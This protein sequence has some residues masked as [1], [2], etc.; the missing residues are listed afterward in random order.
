MFLCSFPVA[1]IG[2][3]YTTALASGLDACIA[4]RPPHAQIDGAAIAPSPFPCTASR[5]TG[6]LGSR[7]VPF[8]QIHL[9]GLSGDHAPSYS[10]YLIALSL[11][12]SNCARAIR[13]ILP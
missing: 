4:G 10:S 12:V 1:L 6:T 5:P 2:L 9:W 7:L 8:L 11:S 13:R 3:V